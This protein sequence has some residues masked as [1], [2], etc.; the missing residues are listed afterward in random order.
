MKAI[1]EYITESTSFKTWCIS[2]WGGGTP[3]YL[4][5]AKTKERA[6]E[7]VESTWWKKYHCPVGE[8][9]DNRHQTIDNLMEVPGVFGIR[10][11]IVDLW[12]DIID[13]K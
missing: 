11:S 13:K 12:K 9:S 3:I 10:E 2:T 7:L 5:T 1:N 8:L 4:V 6:W